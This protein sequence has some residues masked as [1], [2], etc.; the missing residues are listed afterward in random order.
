MFI[1]L[2]GLPSENYLGA[3]AEE[4]EPVGLLGWLFTC[5]LYIQTIIPFIVGEK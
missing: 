1:L 2:S 4:R 5:V 3:S